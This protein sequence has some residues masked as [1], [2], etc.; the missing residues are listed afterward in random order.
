M[1]VWH[2]ENIVY[3]KH[4]EQCTAQLAKPIIDEAR[5]HMDAILS[6]HPKQ[7]VFHDTQAT[8][9][10]ENGYL[11]AWSDVGKEY[12][13]RSVYVAVVPNI[14]V[15]S[16]VKSVMFLGRFDVQIVKSFEEAAAALAKQ[17]FTLRPETEPA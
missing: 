13:S 5:V 8:K 7:V 15:R 1:K 4:P 17:G 6:R 3:V 14:W 11:L 10:V 2:F 16:L 12:Q 9:N